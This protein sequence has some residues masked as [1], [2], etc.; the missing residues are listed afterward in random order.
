MI[1]GLSECTARRRPL[2]LRQPI[3][4]NCRHN[5]ASPDTGTPG[6]P[7]EEKLMMP[8]PVISGMCWRKALPGGNSSFPVLNERG[9]PSAGCPV[10]MHNSSLLG[11]SGPKLLA[12]RLAY[13]RLRS[14]LS[15]KAGCVKSEFINETVKNE[16]SGC[17][18]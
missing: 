6:S 5:S 7:H 8:S 13:L 11:R 16:E 3:G 17:S 4:K 18:V 15:L 9:R 14:R 2:H 1:S 10:K 12:T